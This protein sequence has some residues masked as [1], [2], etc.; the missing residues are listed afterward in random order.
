MNDMKLAALLYH[1]QRPYLLSGEI[2]FCDA[3]CYSPYAVQL[4]HD[5]VHHWRQIRSALQ[6]LL[7]PQRCR[8]RSSSSK[9]LSAGIQLPKFWTWS[10]TP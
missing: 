7:F 10:L 8:W 6:E 1:I 5:S 2:L 9:M 3:E 4:R